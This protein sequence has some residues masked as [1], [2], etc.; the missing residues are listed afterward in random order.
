MPPK[1][2]RSRVNLAQ[3]FNQNVV[4]HHPRIPARNQVEWLRR[5]RTWG[6]LPKCGKHKKSLELEEMEFVG[7]LKNLGKIP[8]H[9]GTWSSNNRQPTASEKSLNFFECL[10]SN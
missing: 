1:A 8:E 5:S 3:G 9:R 2:A 7:Y 6:R 4:D 10:L